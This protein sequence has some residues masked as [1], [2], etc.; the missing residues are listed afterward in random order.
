MDTVQ[1]NDFA[2]KLLA[3]GLMGRFG[4]NLSR[5]WDKDLYT[6]FC[7]AVISSCHLL[8]RCVFLFKMVVFYW[9][10][11]LG[12][13][14]TSDISGSVF[15]RMRDLG[16][17]NGELAAR[18]GVDPAQITR[19]LKGKTNMTLKTL[20]KLKVALDFR[21]DSG[22]VYKGGKGNVSEPVALCARR[23]EGLDSRDERTDR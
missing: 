7:D 11:I 10:S 19:I 22:F 9:L 14:E 3:D 23:D 18:M 8:N 15:R 1:Q 6:T 4:L 13:L 20:A 16:I 12:R 5:F 17:N 21:L 2:M